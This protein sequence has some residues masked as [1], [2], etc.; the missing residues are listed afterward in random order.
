[1][2]EGGD[3]N[4]ELQASGV[5]EAIEVLI[6]PE[7]G[8]R[9]AKIWVSE[10]D[11]VAP[12]EPLI[13]IE[14]KLLVSQLH[15]AE[16]ALGIAEANYAL[17]AAGLSNEQKN[18]AIS[19]AELA[20]ISSEY[21]LSKLF[22]DTDLFAAQALQLAESYERDLENLNNPDFLQ[23]VALKAIADAEKAIEDAERRFHSVSSTA[24][25]AD[26]AA[27]EAQVILSKD[28]LEDAEEDYEPYE[29]KPADNLSR[30]NFRAQLAAAQQVY[31]AAVRKLNALRGTGTKSDIAVAEANLVA[32][33]AKLFEANRE[34]ERIKDGPKDS[35]IALLEAQIA[36]AY[37]DFETYKNGPDPDDIALAESQ[38]NNAKAQLALARAD[39]PTQEELDVVKAQVE[40][41]QTYLEAI[42]VQIDLMVVKSPVSGVVMTRSI[43]PGE[44]VQ[45]GLATMTIGRL[46]NLMITVYIPEDKYG[47]I[48]LGDI[49]TIVADSFPGETFEAT[50][51][52]IA[53]RAE[54]TPRNI[55]TKEDRQTTVYAIELSV[56]DP[57]GKLK[58]GMPTDVQFK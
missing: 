12:G 50:V 28:A 20:L 33:K 43:E 39:I 49:A 48:Q 45:P 19:A 3:N 21:N 40:S 17:I 36:D 4:T 29:D 8:G 58:P 55:Q 23:A 22:D 41:A 56:V 32:A 34:W 51:T 52:R 27:A 31:D 30:A 11:W 38:V 2:L 9:V 5:V 24:D 42:Q 26:I 53:D 35:D 47:Q 25:E 1:M 14:D 10:G 7:I 44:V 46:D 37:Q 13:Q 18:A 15:Q 57:D 16:S 54:Y 6:A